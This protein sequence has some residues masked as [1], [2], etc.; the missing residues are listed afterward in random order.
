M[1]RP[2]PFP[3]SAVKH[4]IA[5]GSSCIA[6]ARVGSRQFFLKKPNLCSAFF[7]VGSRLEENSRLDVF[8][9]TC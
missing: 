6:S 4:S 2:D 5:D 8:V 7:F 3:N 9:L 1:V